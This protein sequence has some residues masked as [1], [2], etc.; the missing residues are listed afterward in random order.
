MSIPESAYGAEVSRCFDS[1]C[2][3]EDGQA[4]FEGDASLAAEDRRLGCME[5]GVVKGYLRGQWGGMG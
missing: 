1:V 5:N 2:I 3:V 4:S